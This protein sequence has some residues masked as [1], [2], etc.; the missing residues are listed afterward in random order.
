MY[1]H[2]NKHTYGVFPTKGGWGKN[3]CISQKFAYVFQQENPP[4]SR[5]SPTTN[6]LSH[7][8]NNNFHVAYQNKKSLAVTS[9]LQISFFFNSGFI[10]TR[11]IHSPI[12][13][14]NPS[15]KFPPPLST[16]GNP[17]TLKS[18]LRAKEREGE[19][20][21][22]DISKIMRKNRPSQLSQQQLCGSSCTWTHDAQ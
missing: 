21:R 9:F 16:R 10:Y 15:S 5:Q 13:S 2:V 22:Y 11:V 14:A 17:P 4:L 19:I 20:P 12:P 6:V 1:V 3:P 7:P 18:F 8:G